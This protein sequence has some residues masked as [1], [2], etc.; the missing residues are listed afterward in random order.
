MVVRDGAVVFEHYGGLMQPTDTHLVHVG[1]E[2]ADVDARRCAG[3]R[4]GDRPGRVRAR[5]HSEP[6]WHGVG[7]AHA[8]APARHAPGTR[9]DEDD[10]DDPESDGRLIE[11]VS[12]YISRARTDLP[13]QHVRVDYAEQQHLAITADPSS[14][15]RSFPMRSAGRC[16]RHQ[17]ETFPDLFSRHIWSKIARQR[18]RHHRRLRRFPSSKAGSAPPSKILARAGLTCHSAASSTGEQIAPREWMNRP[19]TYDE[20]L[21]WR[22]RKLPLQAGARA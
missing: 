3:R 20:E 12:G 5:L 11:E 13:G 7:R 8:A 22:A 6:A 10:Y 16:A 9:F 14:T 21:I 1:V 17:G 15:D 2:I 18:R 4:R 19:T